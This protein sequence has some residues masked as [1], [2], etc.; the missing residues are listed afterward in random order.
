MAAGGFVS[1]NVGNA[2]DGNSVPVPKVNA[3]KAL[4]A[5][6]CIGCGACV[7]S[8]KNA[9]ALLFVGAKVSQYALLPQGQAE[10]AQRVQKMVAQMDKE[11]FGSCTNTSEC[12]AACPAGISVINISQLNR[13]FLRATIT[14]TT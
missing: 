13:E 7:A 10:R 2:P 14:A 8:C 4:D 5:A 3:D 11:G 9:S 12:E 6:V 1:V